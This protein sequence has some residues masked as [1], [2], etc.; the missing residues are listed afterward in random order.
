MAKRVWIWQKGSDVKTLGTKAPWYVSWYEGGKRRSKKIGAKTAA[1]QYRNR[2]ETALNDDRY[3]GLTGK[4]WAEYCKEYNDEVLYKLRPGGRMSAQIA[5][6]HYARL[7][8]PK[9]MADVTHRSLARFGA[10]RLAEKHNGKPISRATVNRD[11]RQMRAFLREAVRRKYLA[12]APVVDFLKE[13][14]K[15]PSYVAPEAFQKLYAACD[16]ATRPEEQ[17]YLPGDWW[18][19]YLVWLYLTGW[20]A[21]EPL[22]IRKEDLDTETGRVHL[23]AENTKGDRDEVLRFHPMIL[24]HLRPIKTL[25]PMVLPWPYGRRDLWDQFHRI[26][27]AAGVRK[28][29][30]RYYGFHDLRRGFATLNVSR[31]SAE[32]LQ[33]IMRHKDFSTTRRYI[34]MVQTMDQVVNDIYVPKLPTKKKSS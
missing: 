33:R 4:S 6:R 7:M 16:A 1:R 29:D 15:I 14:T 20:R 32:A 31:M 25:Q 24:E 2:L 5:L 19:A 23:K 18:R 30:G 10:L 3:S 27:E 13:P 12:S 26:Q 22:S 28:R 21:M 9:R 34:N 17:G 8:K 11:L